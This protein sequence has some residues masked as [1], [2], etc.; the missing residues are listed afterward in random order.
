MVKNDEA[1][2]SVADSLKKVNL[3]TGEITTI[4]KSKFLNILPETFNN[5]TV[6]F[7]STHGNLPVPIKA[8][9]LLTKLLAPALIFC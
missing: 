8:T 1:Y 7:V 2:F 3:S 9:T 4:V 6:M 5:G